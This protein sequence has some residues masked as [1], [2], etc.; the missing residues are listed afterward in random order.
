[1]NELY[2][3]KRHLRAT[4]SLG[5]APTQHS[6]RRTALR[7]APSDDFDFYDKLTTAPGA[8]SQTEID[9]RDNSITPPKKTIDPLKASTSGGPRQTNRPALGYTPRDTSIEDA[10]IKRE[11]DFYRNRAEGLTAAS[12]RLGY[13][14]NTGV[15]LNNE[16]MLKNRAEQMTARARE[17][18]VRGNNTNPQLGFDPGVNRREIAKGEAWA[19]ARQEQIYKE[20][21][22]RMAAEARAAEAR[23]MVSGA[24]GPIQ[25]GY[26]PTSKGRLRDAANAD[27]AAEEQRM[28]KARAKQ[29]YADAKTAAEIEANKFSTKVKAGV[30]RLRGGVNDLAE[31]YDKTFQRAGKDFTPNAAPEGA[32]MLGKGANL[33]KNVGGRAVN[34]LGNMSTKLVNGAGKAA[35]YVG[36]A[37][38]AM[39]TYNVIT[40]ANATDDDKINAG[41][42]G[43]GKAAS[44]YAGAKLVGGAGAK[45][46]SLLGPKGAVVGGLGGSLIG[47]A[48]GY[49]GGE[50]LVRKSKSMLGAGDELTS[51]KLARLRENQNPPVAATPAADVAPTPA[52]AQ[53]AQKAAPN[54]R[55][56]YAAQNA[57]MIA[58]A[59]QANPDL[60]GPV[61]RMAEFREASAKAAANG[62]VFMGRDG[63]MSREEFNKINAPGEIG[64][65]RNYDRMGNL[66]DESREMVYTGP[67]MGWQERMSEK[68]KE[69]KAAREQAYKEEEERRRAYYAEFGGENRQALRRL[70]EM[71]HTDYMNGL[72][73]KAERGDRKAAKRYEA[74]F[75]A[76]T[77][78]DAVR[79]TRR[80]SLRSAEAAEA[81]QQRAILREERQSLRDYNKTM[82]EQSNLRLREENSRVSNEIANKKDAR[83][84]FENLFLT[85]DGKRDEQA[86]AL[87]YEQ[88]VAASGGLFPQMSAGERAPYVPDASSQAR[89]IRGMQL[90]QNSNILQKFGIIAPDMAIGGL[91]SDEEL[92]EATL[93]K[94]GFW[95]GLARPKVAWGDY[96][97]EGLRET[98]LFLSAD[99]MEN[100]LAYLKRK[101]IQDLTK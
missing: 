7:S 11:Q 31:N 15:R 81:A 75:K 82:A 13:D 21:A 17:A 2:D 51:E 22:E 85:P 14:P 28:Y 4:T 98:P 26:D 42:E 24:N 90:R 63:Y 93:S 43:A 77:D 68:G 29:M 71:K 25:I 86:E 88:A 95:E 84:E 64:Q 52:P 32:G 36:T 16:R 58:K 97:I 40:D 19:N 41:V 49:F 94:V 6:G 37:V 79:E 70:E 8:R 39:D 50:E 69:M 20:R 60:R 44:A 45:L 18:I 56:P 61:D 83:G 101:G 99:T 92:R 91:P 72:R 30:N 3:P 76:Q 74:L 78:A 96:K 66:L 35:P 33:A 23:K 46:G 1:M 87:A 59:N 80:S 89:L 27:A 54:L 62:Q 57:A 9:I 53:Q 12:R 38:S 73:D 67:K 47:G 34:A 55:D 48:A 100:D 65:T 10:R 5:A